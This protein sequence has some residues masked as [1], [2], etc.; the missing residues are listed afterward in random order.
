MKAETVTIMTALILLKLVMYRLIYQNKY[1][2]RA[3]VE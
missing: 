1:R 3:H 2:T